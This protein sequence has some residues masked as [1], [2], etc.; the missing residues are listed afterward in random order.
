MG[1]WSGAES[2]VDM[3]PSRRLLFLHLK[4]PHSMSAGHRLTVSEG[5]QDAE[6]HEFRLP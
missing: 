5:Y 4:A 1:W 6:F 2:R 3:P